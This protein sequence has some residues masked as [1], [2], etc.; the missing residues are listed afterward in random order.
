MLAHADEEEAIVDSQPDTFLDAA[1]D[2]HKQV[3][4]VYRHGRDVKSSCKVVPS[5]KNQ[6][7]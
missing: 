4:Y 3:K 7:E 6:G 2:A 5:F 1:I